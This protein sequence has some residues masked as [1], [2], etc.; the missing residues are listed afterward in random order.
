MVREAKE[1]E[2]EEEEEEEEEGTL[3]TMKSSLD[4]CEDS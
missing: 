3:E 4:I 1:E 2:A